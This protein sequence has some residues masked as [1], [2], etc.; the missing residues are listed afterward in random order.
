MSYLNQSQAVHAENVANANTPGYKAL[1]ISP[2]SFGDT[3]K[4]V[5]ATM[6]VTDPR[7]IVPASAAR[8]SGAAIQVKRSKSG[9]AQDVEQESLKVSTTGLEYQSITSIFHK[10]ASFFRLAVKGS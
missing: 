6:V 1:E 10:F 9:D 3:L 7:H 4:Q 8:A 5:N 2:F